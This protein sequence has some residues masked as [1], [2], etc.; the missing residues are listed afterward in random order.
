MH[1]LAM[2]IARRFSGFTK[3]NYKK[4]KSLTKASPPE[5]P[6]GSPRHP[7]MEYLYLLPAILA[8]SP[9]IVAMRHSRGLISQEIAIYVFRLLSLAWLWMICAVILY[10][11]RPTLRQQLPFVSNVLRATCLGCVAVAPIALT[12][13]ALAHNQNVQVVLYSVLEQSAAWFALLACALVNGWFLKLSVTHRAPQDG[14]TLWELLSGAMLMT[15]TACVL[16]LW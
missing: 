6:S 15:L 16:W 12:S 3:P 7:L 14:F 13:L 5:T 9:L 11:W 2:R 4:S 1:G 8:L 10:Y